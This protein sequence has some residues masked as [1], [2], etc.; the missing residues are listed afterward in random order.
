MARPARQR[1][2]LALAAGERGRPTVVDAA[3]A[4]GIERGGDLGA[5]FGALDP[6]VRS[7]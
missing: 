5:V 1:H 4:D 6:R 2:P 3:E 7:G